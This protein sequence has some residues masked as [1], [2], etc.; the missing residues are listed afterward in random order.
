MSEHKFWPEP[1]CG[2]PAFWSHIV[3]TIEYRDDKLENAKWDS[4]NSIVQKR[5]R[6]V[7]PEKRVVCSNCESHLGFVY[8]DGP[9]PHFKRFDVNSRS[10]EFK[11]KP[12]FDPPMGRIDKEKA[13]ELEE[14]QRY[15]R[16]TRSE[17]DKL[18][19]DEKKLGMSPFNRDVSWEQIDRQIDSWQKP[20]RD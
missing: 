5:V 1:G 8:P 18:L 14:K 4:E 13:R 10:L 20:G 11:E 3:D 12:W 2:R 17:Y 9:A 6:D 16:W 19:E 7:A 15:T